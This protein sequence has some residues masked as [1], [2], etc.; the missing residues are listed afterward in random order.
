M[1]FFYENPERFH[2]LH[3][4]HDPD[5]GHMR[6][7]VDTPEDLE[8]LRQTVAHFGGR[9]DLSWLDVVALLEQHPELAEINARVRHKPQYDVDHRR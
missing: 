1:P 5:Y 2:T 3:I 4:K 7:T 8:M 6:W 9:D